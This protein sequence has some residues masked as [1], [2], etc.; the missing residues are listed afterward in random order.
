MIEHLVA[1][2][3]RWSFDVRHRVLRGEAVAVEGSETRVWVAADPARPGGLKALPISPE[4]IA[5]FA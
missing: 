3:R 5:R 2:W 1:E 4:I